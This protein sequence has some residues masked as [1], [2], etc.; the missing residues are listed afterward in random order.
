MERMSELLY[1]AAHVFSAFFL[2]GADLIPESLQLAMRLCG[3]LMKGQRRLVV[4]SCNTAQR[5]AEEGAT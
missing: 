4:H 2:R 5:N 1:H 3:Y